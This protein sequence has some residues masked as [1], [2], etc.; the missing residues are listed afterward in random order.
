MSFQYPTSVQRP[1]VN[2]TSSI[3]EY[4]R[5][6]KPLPNLQNKPQVIWPQK[7]LEERWEGKA[8][9]LFRFLRSG[10]TSGSVPPPPPLSQEIKNGKRLRPRIQG[11]IAIKKKG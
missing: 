1:S 11:V 4:E 6:Q 5:L 10:E 2:D 9:S 7:A 3:V 8:T